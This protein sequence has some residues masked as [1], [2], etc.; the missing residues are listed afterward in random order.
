[1]AQPRTRYDE[2]WDAS[3]ALL[4]ACALGFATIFQVASTAAAPLMFDVAQAEVAYDQRTREPIVAFRFAP[5]SARRLAL[6]WRPFSGSPP[7]TR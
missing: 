3:H 1:M 6:S 5:D 4:L 7:S 2:P